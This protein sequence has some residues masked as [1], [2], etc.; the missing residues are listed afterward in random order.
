MRS[1]PAADTE[2]AFFAAQTAEYIPNHKRQIQNPK[3]YS[4]PNV[5]ITQTN[6]VWA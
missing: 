1:K 6:S 2:L 5:Q 4:N 3:Q